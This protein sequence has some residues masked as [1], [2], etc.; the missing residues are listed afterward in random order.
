MIIY[1]YKKILHKKIS[2]HVSSLISLACDADKR[3]HSPAVKAFADFVTINQ[4]QEMYE[5]G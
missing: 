5:K 3:L 2:P 1:S 4:L